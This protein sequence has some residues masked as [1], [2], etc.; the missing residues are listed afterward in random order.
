MPIKFLNV[1]GST[2]LRSSRPAG[3]KFPVGLTQLSQTNTSVDYIVVGGG[4]G[5]GGPIGSDS[6]GTAGGGR[7][8]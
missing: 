8:V 5:G 7:V 2:N 3:Y 4:G 1:P 6:Y